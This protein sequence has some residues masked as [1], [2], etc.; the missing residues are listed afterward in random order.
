MTRSTGFPIETI[1]AG[2][3]SRKIEAACSKQRYWVTGE[4]KNAWKSSN[5]VWSFDLVTKESSRGQ[6]EE[7]FI[8]PCQI[9]HS[10][11]INIDGYLRSRG[12]SLAAALDNGMSLK[13]QGETDIWRNSLKLHVSLIRP[14]FRRT[15]KLH[16]EELQRLADFARS[17]PSNPR[18]GLPRK[19]VHWNSDRGLPVPADKLE[20]VTVIGPERSQGRND[21]R[22]ELK[23]KYNR[24]R[25]VD[26][27][28]INWHREGALAHFSQLV[29]AAKEEG[30]GLVVL[31]RG[32]GHWLG[33]QAFESR[34]LADLIMT[35]EVPVVTAVGH[36]EDVSL[37]DRAAVASFIT[38]SAVAAAITTTFKAQ[39]SKAHKARDEQAA[40]RAQKRQ[41]EDSRMIADLQ[42]E[43]AE[44]ERSMGA[45]H[46]RLTEQES[47][48]IHALL[49]M[50]RRRVRGYSRL[51]SG[52]VVGLA[53]SVF[54]GASAWLEFFGVEPTRPAVLA[55][56]CTAIIAAWIITWR[57]E[58]SRE[59]IKWP[60][61]DHLRRPP[62][63]SEWMAEIK[64][65]R[66]IRRL[67][68][69]QRHLPPGLKDPIV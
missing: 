34:E 16:R 35:A 49:D 44:A 32:G 7:I 12:S 9:R 14:E 18:A 27:Q 22:F 69:L 45:L 2:A 47:Q 19:E 51:A 67:R 59:K 6:S 5:S 15:G 41:H 68:R 39:K 1:S 30:H 54:F 31:V 64:K 23:G 36:A 3:L 63:E 53:V 62:T 66:T 48:H 8:I 20:G 43:L 58:V 38:P 55:T 13:V 25:N 17:Y 40:A 61:R 10:D 56:R 65:V 37:A 21:L 52:L 46:R 42:T 50:A 60:A 29:R 26:Y 24:P 57:L 11:A 33:M 28:S 4:C